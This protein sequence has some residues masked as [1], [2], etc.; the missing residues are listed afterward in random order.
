MIRIIWWVPCKHRAL[1]RICCDYCDTEQ[2]K[3]EK[4]KEL[5]RLG[6]KYEIEIIED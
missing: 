6:C 5:I 4:I 2:E 1:E 3:D